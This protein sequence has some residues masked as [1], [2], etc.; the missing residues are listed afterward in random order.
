MAFNRGSDA[1]SA[2][3]LYSRR[4]LLYRRHRRVCRDAVLA[5]RHERVSNDVGGIVADDCSLYAPRNDK[6]PRAAGGNVSSS[7]LCESDGVSQRVQ[8]ATTRSSM[9]KHSACIKVILL[10][11]HISK[12]KSARPAIGAS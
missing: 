11:Y 1:S 10:R 7:Y 6:G 9:D 4:W 5:E 2:W 12:V 3:R 8:W